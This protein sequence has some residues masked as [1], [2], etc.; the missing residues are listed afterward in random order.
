MKKTTF[1]LALCLI[2]VAPAY[3]SRKSPS[4]HA[5]GRRSPAAARVV[6]KAA[7][8]PVKAAAAKPRAAQKAPAKPARRTAN[9]ARPVDKTKAASAQPQRRQ[10]GPRPYQLVDAQICAR[11]EGPSRSRDYRCIDETDSFLAGE[12]VHLWAKFANI[13][14]GYRYLLK[15]YRDGQ[16]IKDSK[17]GWYP[18]SDQPV[19]S[20]LVHKD[21]NT[22]PGS[23]RVDFLID[24]GDGYEKVASRAFDVE[25]LSPVEGDLREQCH[26]PAEEDTWAFCPHVST[27]RHRSRGIAMANDNAAWD[28]NLR[29]YADANKEV[30][31]VAPGRVV[32]YGNQWMP[33][34]GSYA[35]V[36]IEHQTAAGEKW[37]SGYLHMRRDSV[38]LEVGQEVDLDTP[39]GRVGSSGTSNSHL[40]LAI[41]K[42]DNQLGALKSFNAEFRPRTHSELRR[43][44]GITR[45]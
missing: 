6:K 42:G 26:W 38:R 9:S 37:W 44:A 35:A 36:L 27:G 4:S 39:I 11:V 21:H 2:L 19:A 10:R 29:D 16:L 7:A 45:D 25:V 14:A 15:T 18:K 22:I 13:S 34:E 43:V 23:Y 17:S 20:Y 40:H 33:G 28:V 41:Y 1:V 5:H 32:K 31:P 8:K 3:A 30:F 24:V 12:T